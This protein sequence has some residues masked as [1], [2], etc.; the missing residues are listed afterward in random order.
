MSLNKDEHIREYLRTFI[1]N[2]EDHFDKVKSD[3]DV[4]NEPAPNVYTTTNVA[5]DRSYDAAATS[6]TELAN[7]LGTL[8]TD[9]KTKGILQ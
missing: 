2:L 7:V 9:L 6:T 5:T 4:L 3:L 1:H 8:I